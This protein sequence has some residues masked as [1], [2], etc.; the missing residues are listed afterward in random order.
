MKFAD[1][2]NPSEKFIALNFHKVV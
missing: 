2:D 1:H